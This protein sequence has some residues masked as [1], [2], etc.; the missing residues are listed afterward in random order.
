MNIKEGSHLVIKCEDI[1]KY[2]SNDER[3]TI[4]NFLDKITQGRE[5][6]NKKPINTYYICNV[7]EPYADVVRGVILA[8]EYAKEQNEAVKMVEYLGEQVPE[9]LCTININGEADDFIGCGKC[10]EAEEPGDCENCIV[11]KIF[12]DYAKLT[13]Q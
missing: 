13:S 5:R 2:L 12:Q 6:D 1:F 4:A 3:K 11:N 7:D 9:E 10:Q 8:G